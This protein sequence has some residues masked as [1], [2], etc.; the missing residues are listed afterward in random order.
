MA[1]YPVLALGTSLLRTRL[2]VE[3]HNENAT[4][5]LA[6]ASAFTGVTGKVFTG[7]RARIAAVAVPAKGH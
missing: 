5:D 7:E 2:D 1:I 4:L 3:S 6:K